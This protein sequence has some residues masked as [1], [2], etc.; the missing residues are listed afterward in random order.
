[1]P[2]TSRSV[3]LGMRCSTPATLSAASPSPMVPPAA[4]ACTTVMRFCV[5]VPVLS[6]QMLVALPMVSQAASW[7]MRLLSFIIFV[8]LYARLMVTASGRP[9]G[10]ATTTMVT[11]RMKASSA[12]S[13]PFS[14]LMGGSG[15]ALQYHMLTMT[16]AVMAAMA[17]PYMPIVFAMTS[18]FSCSGVSADSTARL[19]LMRPQRELRPTAMAIARALPSVT[20][21]PES[22]NGS[23]WADLGRS[24]GSPVRLL[25]SQVQLLPG[26]TTASAGI[27]S[28]DSSRITS[29]TTTSLTFTSCWPPPRCTLTSTSSFTALS[30]R[31][32]SSLE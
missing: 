28:P 18:S 26:Q 16:T 32:C 21:Q 24:S 10:T 17:P 23:L 8:V 25:S 19:A 11:A 4:Q 6:E 30:L 7:R 13:K 9:S 14:Q 27:L 3:R 31:N 22:R 2:L 20:W 12:T 1:M 29:P 5:S 15:L